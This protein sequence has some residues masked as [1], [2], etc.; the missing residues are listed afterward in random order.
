MLQ[1]RVRV[2]W[3]VARAHRVALT[4]FFAMAA[5]GCAASSVDTTASEAWYR[6]AQCS[7][8]CPTCDRED[9]RAS[10]GGGARYTAD[11]AVGI[12]GGG[13]VIRQGVVKGEVEGSKHGSG[14]VSMVVRY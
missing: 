10:E 7:G 5:S 12:E 9:G 6:A 14:V 11:R 1:S 3:E 4:S 2:R 13:W 8:S